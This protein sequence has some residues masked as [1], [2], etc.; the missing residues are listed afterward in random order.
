MFVV[1]AHEYSWRAL[2]FNIGGY[3]KFYLSYGEAELANKEFIEGTKV[4]EN[5]YDEEPKAGRFGI[6]EERDRET[7]NDVE[8]HNGIFILYIFLHVIPSTT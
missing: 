8:K 4:K 7:D 6:L 2:I 1:N 3:C 5:V